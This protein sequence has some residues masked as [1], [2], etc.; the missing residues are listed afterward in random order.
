MRINRLLI[1][2][3]LAATIV[4]PAFAQQTGRPTSP[5]TQSPAVTAQQPSNAAVPDAKIALVNTAAFTD[6]KA[7]IARLVRAIKGVD[8]EFNT[9]RTEL[10]G[11]QTRI[12]TLTDEINKTANVADPKTLQAKQDQLDQLKKDLQRKGEDAQAAYQKRMDEATGPIR[13]D[14]FKALD[15]FARQRGITMTLDASQLAPI[16]MTLSNGM[17]ITAAFIT[18]YNS[19]NPATASAAQP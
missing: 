9:R 10:Q 12:N 7:G 15:A 2:A 19:R 13:D 6:E 4:L 17:D 1:A 11:I 5:A 16:I 14:I 3:A 18:E 8:A